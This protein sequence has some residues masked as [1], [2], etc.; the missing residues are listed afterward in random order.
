MVKHFKDKAVFYKEVNFQKKE[1]I[2]TL[3]YFATSIEQCENNSH[4]NNSDTACN[5]HG[6]WYHNIRAF[7]SKTHFK[8]IR[9]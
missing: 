6:V 1:I 4:Q 8:R 9:H 3:S 2:L 7:I 5:F